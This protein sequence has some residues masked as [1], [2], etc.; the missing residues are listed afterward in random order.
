MKE[1][2]VR[3]GSWV[4]WPQYLPQSH[5]DKYQRKQLKMS[6]SG[7]RLQVTGVLNYKSYRTSFL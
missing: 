6:A 2:R 4:G 5:R 3:N 7:E 1:K